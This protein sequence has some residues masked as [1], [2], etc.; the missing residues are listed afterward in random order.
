MPVQV[1][2]VQRLLSSHVMGVPRQE[3]LTSQASRL[4]QMSPSLQAVPR[5]MLTTHSP[6][7]QASVVQGLPSLQT[8]SEPP[9]VP[10]PHLSPV[11]QPSS[12]LHETVLFVNLQVPESHTSSVQRLSS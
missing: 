4:V 7:T 11:V 9:Q 5:V 10:P 6:P 3:P 1:S 2:V 12:S 8:L